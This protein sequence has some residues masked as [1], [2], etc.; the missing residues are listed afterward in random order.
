[1]TDR[2]QMIAVSVSVLLLGVVLELVRRRKLSLADLAGE[3]VFRF[4]RARQPAFFD[5]CQGVFTRHGFAPVTVREPVD[6]HVLLSEVA[7]ARGVALLPAT[8]RSLQRRGVAYRSLL[9]G[10]E[11]SIGIGLV[12]PRDRPELRELLSAASGRL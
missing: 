5:H 6:Q 8:F 11:L 2:V 9:E 3:P 1:M 10:D 4:E 7:A 12:L